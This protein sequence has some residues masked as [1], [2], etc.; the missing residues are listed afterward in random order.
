MFSEMRSLSIVALYPFL[1]GVVKY[2]NIPEF[3]FNLNPFWIHF[4]SCDLF[5]FIVLV[6][7][8]VES[9]YTIKRWMECRAY[10]DQEDNFIEEVFTKEVCD[11]LKSPE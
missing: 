8:V 3:S 4:S 2:L 5:D 10:E 6:W 1:F 7:L 11:D 9:V